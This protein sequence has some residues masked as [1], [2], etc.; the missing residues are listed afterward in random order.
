[1]D[2]WRRVQRVVVDSVLDPGAHQCAVGSGGGSSGARRAFSHRLAR[3]GRTWSGCPTPYVLVEKM[4]DMAKVT[5]Q[6]FV[7]DL[8]LG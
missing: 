5:P 6:D 1:M 7:M 8:G 2:S 3:P 4:L